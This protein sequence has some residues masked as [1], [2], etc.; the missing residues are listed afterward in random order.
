[1]LLLPD[2]EEDLSS[3]E[4]PDEVVL[5]LAVLAVTTAGVP[6]ELV[7]PPLLSLPEPDPDPLRVLE[8]LL[9]LLLL[10]AFAFIELGGSV[11]LLVSALCGQ[12]FCSLSN[13][14]GRFKPQIG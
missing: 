5:L 2:P 8:L 11:P 7:A 12:L 14:G 10:L 1:L 3:P 4:P 9:L 13:S 6:D